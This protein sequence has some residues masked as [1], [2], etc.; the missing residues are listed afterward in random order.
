MLDLCGYTL[1]RSPPDAETA[2]F[3]ATLGRVESVSALRGGRVE[4]VLCHPL[5][6]MACAEAPPHT[7]SRE[8]GLAQFPYHTDMAQWNYPPRYVL[9]RCIEGS[10]S[11]LTYLLSAQDFL[12]KHLSLRD[13]S[14]AIFARRSPP[15]SVLS[16]RIGCVD[17]GFIRWDPVFLVPVGPVARSALSMLASAPGRAFP[18]P[19]RNGQV[20]IALCEV[21]STLIFDNWRMVHARSS[22]PKQATSRVVERVYLSE[23]K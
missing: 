8:F 19:D 5:R 7:Y 14:R 9:L 23:L 21:G 22:V 20:A 15:H 18:Q 2:T 6:P 17:S 16:T 12:A 10:R 1:I 13:A 11:V 3:A 4:T